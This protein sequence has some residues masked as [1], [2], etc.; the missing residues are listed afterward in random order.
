MLSFSLN[1]FYNIFDT[2]ILVTQIYNVG[3]KMQKFIV[4]ELILRK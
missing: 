4:Q 3:I 1:C 2:S